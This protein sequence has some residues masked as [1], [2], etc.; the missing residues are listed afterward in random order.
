MLFCENVHVLN[1]IILT[2]IENER[3]L[4]YDPT[5]PEILIKCC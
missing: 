3:L 2:I 1:F 4:E 5:Y